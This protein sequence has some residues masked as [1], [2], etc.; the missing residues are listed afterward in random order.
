MSNPFF[1]KY[2]IKKK[3]WIQKIY[4]S[5]LDE[6]SIEKIKM[7]VF[8]LIVI[9]HSIETQHYFHVKN[10]GAKFSN[11]FDIYSNLFNK[12]YLY[13][14]NLKENFIANNVYISTYGMIGEI[15]LINLDDE[16]IEIKCVTQINL[17]HVL[18]LLMYNLMRSDII[19]NN[20]LSFNLIFMNFLRGEKIIYKIDSDK[21]LDIIE[22]FKKHLDKN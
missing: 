6:T 11:M 8:H 2:I 3:E 18:Q 22:I 19:T 14:K 4:K 16:Y 21:F 17:K 12:M 13:V 5:Y 10:K 20:K 15:D 9:L 1:S 7:L